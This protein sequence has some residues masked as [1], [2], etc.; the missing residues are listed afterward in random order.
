MEKEIK[1]YVPG[2]HLTLGPLQENDRLTIMNEVIGRGDYLQKYAGNLDIINC[3]AIYA[4]EVYAN[5]WQQK[6]A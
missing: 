6:Y 3:A 4:A 1:K 2:Y 5:R